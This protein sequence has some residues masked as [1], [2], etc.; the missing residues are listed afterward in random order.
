MLSHNKTD[1]QDITVNTNT[2]FPTFCSQARRSRVLLNDFQTIFR[3]CE[4]VHEGGQRPVE[5][6]EERVS[7]R[8]LFRSTQ[9]CVLQDVGNPC[10]VHGGRPE[11]D[12][13]TQVQYVRHRFFAFCTRSCSDLEVA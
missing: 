3:T 10:A 8:I 11:L 2:L 9:D 4:G 13:E 12:A 6:F 5:H 7:A 1:I